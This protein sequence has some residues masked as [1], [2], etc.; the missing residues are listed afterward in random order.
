MSFLLLL[1]SIPLQ[2]ASGNE[3]D[4][5]IPGSISVEINTQEFS[6]TPLRPTSYAGPELFRAVNQNSNSLRTDHS[7][8]TIQLPSNPI[9]PKKGQIL[10]LLKE[11]Y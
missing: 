4:Y 3:N 2:G 10:G 1:I 6:L 5:V 7:Y 11:F 8:Q 9:P